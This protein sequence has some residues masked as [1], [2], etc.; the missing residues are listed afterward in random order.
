MIIEKVEQQVRELLQHDASG[1]DWYHID[2]VRKLAMQ[3][4]CEEGGDAFIIEMA[5]L[6]HDVPDEK[7]NESEAVG[8]AK[9][10]RIFDSVD[11]Q[12]EA[13][14]HILSIIKNM[15]Y[16]GGNGGVV[17]T[18]EGKV[19]QD[20]DRL[21]ALGAI[22]IARTFAFGGK[23]GD[24][25]YDPEIP[26]R[27]KMSVEEYRNGKSTSLNHFYEKLFKLQ[28]TINTNA[29]RRIAKERHMFMEQFVH[30]FMKEWNGNE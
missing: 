2:R 17:T 6:L 20:A 24:L 5:A 23:K 9:L 28:D 22:G 13:K 29:G 3:I 19:V 4:Q 12:D 25:M 15:S 14:E 27:D 16:K 30:Q 8:M 1:H 26:I 11:I 18:I 7:L 21:D 10:E